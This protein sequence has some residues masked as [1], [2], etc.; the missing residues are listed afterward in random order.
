[1]VLKI[2]FSCYYFLFNIF[3]RILEGRV[4]WKDTSC[5]R[6]SLLRDDNTMLKVF[7]WNTDG[8]SIGVVSCKQELLSI[9]GKLY[10]DQLPL[11]IASLFC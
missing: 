1:M 8:N 11:L 9:L 10:G 2:F 6:C 4:V 3:G 7:L 5:K